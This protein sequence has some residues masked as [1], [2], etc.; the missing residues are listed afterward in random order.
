[1]PNCRHRR[2]VAGNT[3]RMQNAKRLSNINTAF[4]SQKCLTCNDWSHHCTK[5]HCLHLYNI[6]NQV[7]QKFFQFLFN[8]KY[9]WTECMIL[10]S[11]RKSQLYNASDM[12]FRRRCLKN[13]VINYLNRINFP[14]P[15]LKRHAKCREAIFRI[16]S[17]K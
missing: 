2:R 1:M 10:K 17:C 7:L 9:C 3:N 4:V 15:F 13:Y 16:I 12:A 5:N 6:Q 8:L 11:A 14:N